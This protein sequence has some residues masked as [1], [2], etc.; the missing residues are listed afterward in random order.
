MSIYRAG[1]PRCSVFFA[2]VPTC[3]QSVSNEKELE[4]SS[5]CGIR[6]ADRVEL[7]RAHEC[8][9]LTRHVLAQPANGGAPATAH[10]NSRYGVRRKLICVRSTCRQISN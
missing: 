3:A 10:S 8:E 7:D 9:S 6:D 2:S 4:M 1:H 5:R